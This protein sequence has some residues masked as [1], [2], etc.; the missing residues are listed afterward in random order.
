MLA[1]ITVL[2]IQL[3]A[4]DQPQGKDIVIGQSIEIQQ[5]FEAARDL[6][7]KQSVTDLTRFYDHIERVRKKMN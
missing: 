3:F 4:F 6:A 1:L 7:R 5:H 2:T